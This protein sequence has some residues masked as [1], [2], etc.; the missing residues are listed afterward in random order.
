MALKDDK[1]LKKLG[2][3]LNYGLVKN[4]NKNPV[5]DKAIQELERE[6]LTSDLDGQAL[7]QALLDNCLQKVNAN[8]RHCGLSS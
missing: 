4:P 1:T 6:I 3:Q 7:N 5:V 2:V 8:I